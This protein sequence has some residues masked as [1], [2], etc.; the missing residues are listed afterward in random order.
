M[1]T[2]AGAWPLA[3]AAMVASAAPACHADTLSSSSA[4]ISYRRVPCS[5]TPEHPAPNLANPTPMVRSC[6]AAAAVLLLPALSKRSQYDQALRLPLRGLSA[7][8][9][10]LI[11]PEAPCQLLSLQYE[12]PWG[13]NPMH[14]GNLTRQG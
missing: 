1:P 7:P 9:A 13:T 3:A 11:V 10:K 2:G 12:Q 8:R 4:A 14:T 6:S 5:H